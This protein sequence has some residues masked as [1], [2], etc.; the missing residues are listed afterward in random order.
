M[1]SKCDTKISMI[2]EI[3]KSYR[4]GTNYL[5]ITDISVA[6]FQKNNTRIYWKTSF[7]ESE[8]KSSH[9]LTKKIL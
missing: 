9:F 3:T 1:Q 8:L 7:E 2:S 6:N 5:L 4:M